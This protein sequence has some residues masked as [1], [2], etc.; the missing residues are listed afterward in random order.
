MSSWLGFILIACSF[1]IKLGQEEAL[2]KS[3]FGGSHLAHRARTK[4]L[5]PGV[6]LTAALPLR[7][8]AR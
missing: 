5:I 4:R 8:R 3:Q 1:W 2:L 6:H 7:R